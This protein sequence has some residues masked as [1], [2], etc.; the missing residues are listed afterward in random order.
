MAIRSQFGEK[1]NELHQELLTMGMMVEEAVYKAVKSLLEKD[2]DLAKSVL[3]GDKAIN[4]AE[5]GIEKTCFSLIALQQPVGSDL[6]RIATTLKVA[7]DLERMADHAVSFAQTTISLKD[8]KYAKPL[9]DIPKMGELVQKIVRDSL[10]AYIKMDHEAAVEIAKQD[11]VIDEYFN[12]VFTDLIDLMG[13]DKNL[14][15]Q[16]THLLLA[17]QYLERIGD[18]ATNICEWI[19][20]MS[21]GKMVELN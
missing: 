12:K 4:E 21:Q 18:Y 13:K 5:I 2:V 19:V 20:Y 11:D 17:A 7:T 9:I 15:H 16:G 10:S 3:D 6:R 1:L 14:I 8:E